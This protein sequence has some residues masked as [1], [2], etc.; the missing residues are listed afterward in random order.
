MAVRKISLLCLVWLFMPYPAQSSP[1]LSPGAGQHA[2]HLV[3]GAFSSGDLVSWEKHGFNGETRYQLVRHKDTQVLEAQCRN[4]ASG[5]VRKQKIDLN[6]TPLM[7]WSWRVDNIYEDIDETRREGDDYPASLYVA[8][9]TGLTILSVR[10]LHYVWSSNQP[11][12]SSW[13]SAYTDNVIQVAVRS[14]QDA[15]AGRWYTEAR[16]V[17]EDFKRYFDLDVEQIDSISLMSDCDNSEGEGRAF[18]GDILF[19]P[20]SGSLLSLE[21]PE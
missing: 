12:D 13:H 1:A 21:S 11:Q 7:H 5:L 2:S 16:N 14:G 4:S 6:T 19:G 15:R 20:D 3:V 9:Q 17:K 18:Y 8:V 10:A